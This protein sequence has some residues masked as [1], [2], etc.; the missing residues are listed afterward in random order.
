MK[1]RNSIFLV[2]LISLLLLPTMASPSVVEA[3]VTNAS[4][5]SNFRTTNDNQTLV[6]YTYESLLQWGDNPDQVYN[7]VF[8]EFENRYGINI[9]VVRFKDAHT[10]LQRLI[11]ERL[12][13]QADIVIGLDD[14]LATK[15]KESGIL[16][17]YTPTNLS[18]VR[19]DLVDVLDPE[20]YLVPYDY[21][22]IALVYDTNYVNETT[23]PQISHLAFEDFLNE[24]LASQ[25]IVEDP[26]QSSTGL[27]FLL[28]EIAI[29][30]KILN[31]PWTEWWNATYDK[32]SVKGGW[33]DA[34]DEFLS[35]HSTRHIVVSYGTDGAYSYH[36]YN[37]TRYSATLVYANNSYYGWLQVEGIGIINGT[38]NLNESKAF[39]EW[40]LSD[41]VQQYIPLNNWMYPANTHVQL[42]EDYKYAIDPSK[43]K[44]AN[45]LLSKDEIKQNLD[46]WLISWLEIVSQPPEAQENLD[47]YYI[48]AGII[49]IAVVGL[50]V[51]MLRKK[52]II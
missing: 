48:A 28:W 15:A 3:V 31:K 38:D 44:V 7:A 20:H 17:P 47:I 5:I 27:S 18:L 9:S 26:T 35:E 22:L 43:V 51:I 11:E 24:S 30:E 29:Y 49:A 12:N 2:M 52:R 50:F 25:L 19:S 33:G 1:L 41:E 37:D 36:F 16:E 39:I 13:P 4:T 40:F 42:P 46:S 14:I 32:I 23:Y 10:M 21:G 45:T 34:Y 8:T 6:I